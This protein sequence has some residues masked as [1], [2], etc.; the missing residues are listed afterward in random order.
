MTKKIIGI[1][2]ISFSVI[3]VFLLTAAAFTKSTYVLSKDYTVTINGTSNLHDWE[4]KVEQVS[5][6]AIIDKNDDGSL[7]LTY[8]NI[9]LDVKSIKSDMG[10]IMNNNTYEA[11]KEKANP[12]ISFTISSPV[13]FMINPSAKK[14]IA[15]KGNL[16]IA[17]VTHAITMQV[18]VSMPNNNQLHFEGAQLI[19]MSDYNISPPTAMFGTLKTGNKITLYYK[20]NF[21]IL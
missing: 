11:L 12:T 13:K 21:A 8:L 14:T 10:S 5:G 18:S 19:N 2:Y 17:G 1:K 9:K 7:N 4:E 3:L 15:V 16:Q 20:T 6:S